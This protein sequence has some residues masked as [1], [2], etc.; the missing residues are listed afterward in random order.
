M[1][2]LWEYRFATPD[3]GRNIDDLI[4]EFSVTKALIC[5]YPQAEALAS[6]RDL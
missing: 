4:R 2:M 5:P 6:R 3:I 1:H